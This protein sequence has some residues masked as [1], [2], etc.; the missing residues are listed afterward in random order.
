[1]GRVEALPLQ[2][3]PLINQIDRSP[4][5]A[6]CQSMCTS[7]GVKA[8]DWQLP[9]DVPTVLYPGQLVATASAGAALLLRG[10]AGGACRLSGPGNG[11]PPTLLCAGWPDDLDAEMSSGCSSLHESSDNKKAPPRPKSVVRLIGPPS[12]KVLYQRSRFTFFTGN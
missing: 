9:N 2:L 7:G 8:S 4:V 10:P 11:M 1:A 12:K 6:C 3:A 5:D